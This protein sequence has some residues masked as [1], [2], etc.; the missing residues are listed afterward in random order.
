V[1]DALRV[2]YTA[3]NADGV[4][5]DGASVSAWDPAMILIDAFRKLGTNATAKQV[6][7]YILNLHD[8]F[9]AAADTNDF[10]IGNQRGLS[11]KDCIVVR[12]D[13]SKDTWVRLRVSPAPA[14][15]VTGCP[16]YRT[17][18]HDHRA[19]D[20]MLLAD[21][22]ADVIKV[23]R[24]EGDPFRSF[25]GTQAGNPYFETFNRGKR[26]V[27]L[28]LAHAQ[29]RRRCARCCAMPTF[30]STTSVRAC[31]RASVSIP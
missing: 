18:N 5:P 16:G 6:R 22:G 1:K 4:R 15:D 24:P 26:S 9:R 14:N 8:F 13:V 19:V 30:L 21:L 23:E 25:R 28:D 31:C 12:W 20:A 7:D 2:M 11:A 10:R 17:R 3:M 29:A 27:V